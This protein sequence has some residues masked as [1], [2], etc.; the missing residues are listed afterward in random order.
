MR[1][2]VAEEVDHAHIGRAGGDRRSTSL[3]QLEFA[4]RREAEADEAEE[5]EHILV[6]DTSL[7]VSGAGTNYYPHLP[8]CPA[9][10]MAAKIR[11]FFGFCE[12]GFK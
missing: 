2:G 5:G 7:K 12:L 9:A 1:T 4:H 10:L 6:G 11:D 8:L 3:L